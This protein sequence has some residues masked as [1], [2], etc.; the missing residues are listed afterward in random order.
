MDK[1]LVILANKAKD[2]GLNEQDISYA[3]N[4]VKYREYGLAIDQILSQVAEYDINIDNSFLNLAYSL[5][6]RMNLENEYGYL[7]ELKNNDR[8]K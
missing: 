1:E 6:K 3:L 4:Y 2:L 7:K 8:I 5:L